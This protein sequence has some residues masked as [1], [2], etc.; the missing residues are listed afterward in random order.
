MVI[1]RK[2][3]GERLL[4]EGRLV[5]AF[6]EG[7][8]AAAKTCGERGR[9]APFDDAFIRMALRARAPVIP[10]AVAGAE[11]SF[12]AFVRAERAARL[13]G[14]PSF[15]ITPLFPW[16]GPLGLIPLPGRWRLRFGPAI[17]L[18]PYGPEHAEDAALVARLANEVR[19]AV[20]ELFG[21]MAPV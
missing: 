15:P 20:S 14:L 10:C 21:E 2:E 16:L 12:P 19:N 18:E 5:G 17:S 7:A 4:L 9:L 11:S 3:N 8:E 13:F 1:A 6:P